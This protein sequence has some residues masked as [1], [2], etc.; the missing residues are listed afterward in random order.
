VTI[1]ELSR[2]QVPGQREAGS[3][4]VGL[5]ALRSEIRDVCALRDT[6]F[7][8]TGATTPGPDGFDEDSF[9]AISDHLVVW[10]DEGTGVESPV[11]TYRLLP[12]QANTAA[13]RSTGLYAHTEFDL[14]P[15]EG[16]LPYAVEAG[17]AC[18]H[19]DHRSSTPISLLWRGI[20]RYMA[21]GGHRYLLGCASFPLADGGVAARDFAQRQSRHVREDAVAQCRP[22][23]PLPAE[24]LAGADQAA[25]SAG[26]PPLIRGYLRLGAMVAPQPS[27]DPE[28]G[29]ADFLML[30][31]LQQADQR[32]LR[33]FLA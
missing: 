4:R 33:R 16:L 2:P 29:T 8:A 25:P 28:F 14:A 6:V 7:R 24:M 22:R 1:L 27:W 13:P 32:Y 31:D 23:R 30:L 9:D 11:A 21:A 3:Y 20:A 10:Y 12:P 5:T 15:L 17:R 26:I 19:P 18:V